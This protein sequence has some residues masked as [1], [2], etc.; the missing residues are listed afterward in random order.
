[1]IVTPS[2]LSRLISATL[3]FGVI[4]TLFYLVIFA[5]YFQDIGILE[6][7]KSNGE[8]FVSLNDLPLGL[9]LSVEIIA[10]AIMLLGSVMFLLALNNNN[11]RY[12]ITIVLFFVFA[13][14]A[15]TLTYRGTMIWGNAEG[16]CNYF[17]SDNDGEYGDYEKACPTTRHTNLKPTDTGDYWKIEHVEPTLESDCIFWFW[18]NTF[19]LSSVQ[20]ENNTN[21]INLQNTM[22]ENMDWSQKH[23]YGVYDVEARCG[24]NTEATDCIPDGRTIPLTI[25]DDL[26]NLGVTITKKIASGVVPDISYCYYWGCS[27]VCNVDRYRVNRMLLYG[28]I[29][30]TSIT[31]ILFGV[32]VAFATGTPEGF[33]SSKKEEVEVLDVENQPENWRPMPV[34][35]AVNRRRKLRF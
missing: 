26:A 9:F 27:E 1:M 31:L 2:R 8:T 12:A 29:T 13:A 23:L 32:S 25:Q 11:T 35:S 24:G 30:M 22:I 28:G 3:S 19:T 7:N 16:Q 14:F 20:V 4:S 15:S 33:D 10:S 21:Y 34:K 17:G 18:D 5:L 6:S